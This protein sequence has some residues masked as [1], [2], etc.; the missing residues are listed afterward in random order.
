MI[1][2]RNNPYNINLDIDIPNN[3]Y[4]TITS[5]HKE[6]KEIQDKYVGQPMNES[7]IHELKYDLRKLLEKPVYWGVKI[8]NNEFFNTE[9]WD[10]NRILTEYK[11]Y[12]PDRFDE[13]KKEYTNIEVNNILFELD[14]ANVIGGYECVAVPF[15]LPQ[16]NDK[17]FDKSI[18]VHVPIINLGSQELQYR[19]R[20]Y[21]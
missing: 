18:R 11:E 14:I 2:K 4:D 12:Y 10:L 3:D 17:I 20:H 1:D 15:D 16:H 9:V 21:W 8:K 19:W 6:L 7:I 13:T 5:L